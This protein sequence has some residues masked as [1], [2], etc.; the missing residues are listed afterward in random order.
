VTIESL[1]NEAEEARCLA[2]K[3]NRPSAAVAAIICKAKL[4]GVWDAP[5][6]VPE[7]YSRMSRM[8]TEEAIAELARIGIEIE[9]KEIPER[10]TLGHRRALKTID[11]TAQRHPTERL[12]LLPKGG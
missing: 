12:R 3:R 10:N 1:I 7:E 9:V 5:E 8:S 11:A 2:M 4:A 6:G